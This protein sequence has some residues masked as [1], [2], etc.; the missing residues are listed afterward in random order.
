MLL[1]SSILIDFDNDI[2]ATDRVSQCPALAKK[3]KW[4]SN[5]WGYRSSV[6]NPP[7]PTRKSFFFFRQKPPPPLSDIHRGRFSERRLVYFVLLV[8][9]VVLLAAKTFR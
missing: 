8:S 7:Q 6:K 5:E 4:C 1:Q 2:I 3:L 9:L